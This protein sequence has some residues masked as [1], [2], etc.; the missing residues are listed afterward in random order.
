MFLHMY[1]H[2]Y[3]KRVQNLSARARRVLEPK[4]GQIDFRLT[5]CVQLVEIY[6]SNE[7]QL[8]QT[9]NTSLIRVRD[10]GSVQLNDVIVGMKWLNEQVWCNL[11]NLCRL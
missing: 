8:R 1:L 3:Q 5:I 11:C 6:A 10:V 4:L 7:N 2:R 9:K